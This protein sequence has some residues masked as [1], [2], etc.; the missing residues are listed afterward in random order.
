M[1]RAIL[2]LGILSLTIGIALP[3]G[4]AFQVP[5]KNDGY[6]TDDANVL[7]ESAEQSLESL[8]TELDQKTKSQ[9]A[10]LTVPSLDG[11]PLE[12]ASLEVARK[13]GIGDKEKSRGL[14]ILF[15]L[16]DHKFRAEIG[17]GLEGTITDGTSG[18]V[19]DR[20][21]RPYFKQG[22]YETGLLEGSKAYASLI[23]KANSVTLSGGNQNVDVHPNQE[24]SDEQG[25][26][27]PII[28]F[29]I[30]FLIPMFFN[31]R[32]GG[33]GYYGS[34]FIGGFGGGGYSGDSGSSFGGFGGGD[35]GGG[36]SSG[37]W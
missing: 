2:A 35:F 36:G 23:A 34:P 31:R 22:D 19:R 21:M 29:I 37:D 18:Q 26:P 17:Y 1:R 14:L 30:L 10:I 28:I 15:A 13:W 6:V 33:S 25:I 24:G 12:Q 3:A 7:S 5:Q 16:N 11:T 8:A 4:A 20:Y 9:I 32:G 27:W